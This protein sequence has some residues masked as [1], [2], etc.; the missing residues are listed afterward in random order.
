MNDKKTAIA[1]DMQF[2]LLIPF[3]LHATLLQTVTALTRVTTSYRAIELDFS[4]A[5]YGAISSGYALLPIFLALPLGRWID[6]G[7]DARAIWVGAAFTLAGNLGFW[8]APSSPLLMLSYTVV[9]GVG[10]LFIMAGHQMFALR[11]SGPISRETVFGHY[12]VALALGQTI[13]PLTI[14]WMAGS[15]A[16]PPTQALFFLAFLTAATTLAVAFSMRPAPGPKGGKGAGDRVALA[17]LLRAPGLVA[18][19]VA[20]VVTVTAMDLIVIYLPLLGVERGIDAGHVGL[21]LTTRAVASIGSR[22]FYAKLMLL[23]GRVPLTLGSMLTGGVAFAAIALPIPLW[24]MY[25]A[26]AVM[27]FGLGLAIVLCLSNVVDL[28]PVS[29]RATAMTMRLS[30][31]RIG[32]FALPLL[33][34]FMGA[35]TGVGAILALTAC[36]LAL[37]GVGVKRAYGRM[38]R[39]KG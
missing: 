25:V 3:L 18:V 10:H 24:A 9:A 31:N 17:D 23:V 34:G 37:S 20:S 13:G 12:M 22:L 11:V 29:A 21:L 33:A 8:L 26:V 6:R 27:G 1:G 30:G 15:A 16:V 32:Q 5:W 14:G 38:Q 4:V 2:R 35:A 36:A 28:A 7:N 19:I 39:P